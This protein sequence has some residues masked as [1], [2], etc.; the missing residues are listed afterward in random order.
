MI[1]NGTQMTQIKGMTTDYI[2]KN[3]KICAHLLNLHHLRAMR[4][5]N[6]IAHI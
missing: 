2:F 1:Q 3:K 5:L 6:N 4:A